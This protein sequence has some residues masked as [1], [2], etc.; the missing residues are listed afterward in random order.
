MSFDLFNTLS[1]DLDICTLNNTVR[2]VPL[3]NASD[4]KKVR[5]ILSRIGGEW[6]I[7]KQVFEFCKCPESLIRRVLE[8]GGRSINKY[9]FYPTPL[10]IQDFIAKHTQV[11][12]FGISSD[13]SVRV[14]EPSMGEGNLAKGLLAH[15]KAEGI[16]YEIKGY[17]ID[18]LN[19]LIARESGFDVDVCDFLQQ[20][21]SG[22]YDLVVMNP[23]FN[24]QTYIKHIQHAQKFLNPLGRLVAVVPTT[25]LSKD[26]PSE[27]E[28]WLVEQIKVDGATSLHNGDFFEPGTFNDA[29]IET[30]VI[31][32]S[33]CEAHCEALNKASYI[34]RTLSEL[35]YQLEICGDSNR[36]LEAYMAGDASDGT[37][38]DKLISDLIGFSRENGVYLCP[39]LSE[40]YK[41]HVL[42]LI[43]GSTLQDVPVGDNF[44]LFAA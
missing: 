34:D 3:L 38:L 35:A 36:A 26:N 44:D 24:G 43:G 37:K 19:A 17:E 28:S 42:G 40:Y 8:A 39:S 5:N 12:F 29:K 11:S 4:Y 2:V 22:D 10:S 20:E 30:M 18:P 7:Q 15:G 9:Q 25:F 16:Q 14:L 13:K 41:R 27:L 1:N 21:P 23:P 6:N 32:L 33:S 31:E